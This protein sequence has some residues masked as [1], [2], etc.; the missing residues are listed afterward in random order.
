MNNDFLH[1]VDSFESD[2]TAA[3]ERTK[4]VLEALADVLSEIEKL[5]LNSMGRLLIERAG[6]LCEVSEGCCNEA[7]EK[8]KG[9]AVTVEAYNK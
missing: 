2:A 6:R 4:A 3:V 7:H 5:E 8:L 1:E 9:L